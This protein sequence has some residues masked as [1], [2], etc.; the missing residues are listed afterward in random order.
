MRRWRVLLLANAAAAVAALPACAAEF[1][2]VYGTLDA[3]VRSL[4]NAIAGRH[5]LSVDSSASTPSRL[6]VRGEHAFGVGWNTH[7]TIEAGVQADTGA[8]TD[9]SALFNRQAYVGISSPYG[10]LDLG[11]QY[12]VG[13]RTAASYDP[14]GARYPGRIPM[15]AFTP[16]A[17]GIVGCQ[18]FNS[19]SCARFSNDVQFSF[20]RDGLVLRA[21]YMAGEQPGSSAG[22]A[23]AV[24]A[25]FSRDGYTLGAATTRQRTL[26]NGLRRNN[27]A[28]A[29]YSDGRLRLSAGWIGD[30]VAGKA[31]S[32]ARWFGGGWQLRPTLAL[33]TAFYR[34]DMARAGQTAEQG[35]YVVV[36]L[37][38]QLSR[39]TALY[40]ESERAHWSRGVFFTP[41]TGGTVQTGV[42]LG[43]TH[44]F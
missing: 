19:Q 35:R 27:T 3:S 12:T 1:V 28:G 4:S 33:T 18:A 2:T 26:D 9:A 31:R 10:S 25:V 44:H 38:Y 30:D 23:R 32:R 7:F 24:G 5:R 20:S 16:G 43:V 39:R 8:Q 29:A 15:V 21:E 11:R 42:T 17:Q 37:R 14:F 13:F 22:S 40:A 41:A 36:E 34:A 6:G